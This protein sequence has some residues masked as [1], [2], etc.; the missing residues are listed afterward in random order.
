MAPSGLSNV[1]ALTGVMQKAYLSEDVASS[2]ASFGA[3]FELV[4]KVALLVYLCL[5]KKTEITGWGRDL[6]K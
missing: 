3:A 4:S 6:G 1:Q 2:A 5:W